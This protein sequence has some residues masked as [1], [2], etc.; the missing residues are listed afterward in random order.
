MLLGQWLVPPP[1]PIKETKALG[2]ILLVSSS[3]RLL[4]QIGD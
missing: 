4:L 1:F 2:T 3:I